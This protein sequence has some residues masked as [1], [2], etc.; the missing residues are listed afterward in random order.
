MAL[1]KVYTELVMALDA[2]PGLGNK[3]AT[4]LAQYL[5]RNKDA[6][7]YRCLHEANALQLCQHCQTFSATPL[8]SLCDAPSSPDYLVVRSV[9]E[10]MQAKEKGFTGRYFVLH[11]L[12]SPAQ[13]VGPKQLGLDKLS[14]HLDAPISLCIALEDSAEGRATTEFIRQLAK[15]KNCQV[16]SCT[17]PQWLET[18]ESA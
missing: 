15:Q 2:L 14:A 5:L 17:W 11:D 16:T 8:C 10:Q 7:L 6:A 13:G 18:H 3:A 4:R 9:E 12:L 1:P